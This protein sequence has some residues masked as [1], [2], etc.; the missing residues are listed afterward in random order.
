MDVFDEKKRGTIFGGFR[1]K[2]F[3]GLRMSEKS[4]SLI[5]QEQLRCQILM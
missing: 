5:P 4:N 1:M 2:D 3:L